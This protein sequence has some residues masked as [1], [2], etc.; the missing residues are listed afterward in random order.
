MTA[1]I[2]VGFCV[3]F[4]GAV[5]LFQVVVHYAGKL[6]DEEIPG[7]LRNTKAPRLPRQ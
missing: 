3:L 2:V 1:G 7:Q 4:A 6:V 5:V